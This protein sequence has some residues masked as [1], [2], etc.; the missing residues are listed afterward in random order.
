M[1]NYLKNSF[2]F[3]G[4]VPKAEGFIIQNIPTFEE[5]QKEE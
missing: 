3:K 4:K 2:P 5:K 1:K